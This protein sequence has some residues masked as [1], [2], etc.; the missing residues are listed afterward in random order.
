MKSFR[1]P[2]GTPLRLISWGTTVC[3]VVIGLIMAWNMPGAMR[4]LALAPLAMVLGGALFTIRGYSIQGDVILVHRLFWDTPLPVAGLLSAQADP[5]AMRGS[6]RLCGNGGMFS[7]T[8]L[9]RNKTLG[10]YRAFVTDSRRAVVL[11]YPRRT[12]VLSP[13][14]PEEFVRELPVA[15]HGS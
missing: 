2:W 15:D 6:I 11:R 9:F 8:G 12:V 4:W 10:N 1:A 13:A 14:E 7:F 3:C 5:A